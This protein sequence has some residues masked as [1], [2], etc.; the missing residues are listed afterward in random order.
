[1]VIGTYDFFEQCPHRL[2]CAKCAFYLPKGPA[3][4]Q[5]LEGKENLLRLRQEIPLGEAELA[6]VT[7]GIGL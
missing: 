6:A 7:D 3:K 2:G 4:A 1:M 5:I